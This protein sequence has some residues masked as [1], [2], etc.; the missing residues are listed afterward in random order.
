MSSFREKF[1]NVKSYYLIPHTLS[2]LRNYLISSK[3]CSKGVQNKIQQRKRILYRFELNQNWTS[4][5]K[6]CVETS[7]VLYTVFGKRHLKIKNTQWVVG[8]ISTCDILSLILKADSFVFYLFYFILY[9]AKVQFTGDNILLK[10]I[11]LTYGD[12]DNRLV[13]AFL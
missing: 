6:K 10:I 1:T 2:H 7:F 4:K 11:T 12:K 5:R 8:A 9:W 3:L 13:L